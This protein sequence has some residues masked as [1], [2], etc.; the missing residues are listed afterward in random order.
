MENEELYRRLGSFE[1]GTLQGPVNLFLFISANC[2]LECRF[3]ARRLYLGLGK[4]E[5]KDLTGFLRKVVFRVD[6]EM[7]KKIKEKYSL[8]VNEILADIGKEQQILARIKR[9]DFLIESSRP[10]DYSGYSRVADLVKGSDRKKQAGLHSYAMR[11]MI[12]K[13][14]RDMGQRMSLVTFTRVVREAADLGVRD[15]FLSGAIGEPLADKGFLYPIMEEIIKGGMTGHIAT[16]GYLWDEEFAVRLVESGWRSITVSIDGA[17]NST[18]D[19]LRRK[20]GSFR[21]AIELIERLDAI[22]TEY[23]SEFP[24]ISVSFVVNRYNY[25]ELLDHLVLMEK[26][27]VRRAYYSPMRL[28]TREAADELMMGPKDI[29]ELIDIIRKGAD[30][31]NLSGVE[32]N[33]ASF[34]E[35]PCVHEFGPLMDPRSELFDDVMEFIGWNE[36]LEPGRTKLDKLMCSEP[37]RSLVVDANGSVLHCCNSSI[38]LINMNV[39]DHSLREI[40]DSPRYRH[41][42]DN[43]TGGKLPVECEF[44]C[45]D[46]TKM[47]QRS[48][49]D[50]YRKFCADET[51]RLPEALAHPLRHVDSAVVKVS[52]G[53]LSLRKKMRVLGYDIDKE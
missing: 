37:W 51:R 39:M 3:C 30:K 49:M 34:L 44:N 47:L 36:P 5:E 17:R 7:N 16:N 29:E 13:L 33:I 8:P 19:H 48:L 40:W 43:F 27:G 21:R 2:P 46:S 38:S 42:R 28:Y 53:N 31:W 24:E 50:G 6:G 11:K 12:R 32:N 9:I 25:G 10:L 41:L 26:L 23:G 35:S 22:K 20:T 1:N 14:K 52:K 18:H 4:E 45:P 15:I